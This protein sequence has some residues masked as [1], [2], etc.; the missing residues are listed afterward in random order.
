MNYSAANSRLKHLGAGGWDKVGEPY[1][2]LGIQ[3]T[4]MRR[5]IAARKAMLRECALIARP[6]R[7]ATPEQR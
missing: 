5:L 3:S 7:L 1:L 6:H 2:H 4:K